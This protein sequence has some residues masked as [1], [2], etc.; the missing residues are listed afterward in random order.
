MPRNGKPAPVNLAER[1][2]A[3]WISKCCRASRRVSIEMVMMVTVDTNVLSDRLDPE[4]QIA[5]GVL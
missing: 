3:T 1:L 2:T 4:G 5:P